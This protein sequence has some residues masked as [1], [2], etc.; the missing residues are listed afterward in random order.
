MSQNKPKQPNT[1]HS[2]PNGHLERAK[3]SQNNPK[4]ASM[5]QIQNEP[6]QPKTS[7]KESEGYLKQIKTT[8]NQPQ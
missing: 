2:K 6:K 1:S 8:Q 7:H 4:R 5:N 3:I